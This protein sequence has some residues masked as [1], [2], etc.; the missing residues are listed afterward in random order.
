MPQKPVDA[1]N[2]VTKPTGDKRSTPEKKSSGTTKKKTPS[3]LEEDGGA[4]KPGATQKTRRSK[5]LGD[6]PTGD[7]RRAPL[8]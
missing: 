2:S 6:K 3:L 7:P 1:S 8:T 4:T 5:L